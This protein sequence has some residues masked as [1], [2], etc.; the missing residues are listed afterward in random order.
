MQQR[1]KLSLRLGSE[2]ADAP[3][4][5]DLFELAGPEPATPPVDSRNDP[6]LVDDDNPVVKPEAGAAMAPICGEPWPG[7]SA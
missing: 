7:T 1:R 4:Q 2:R 5:A 6:A 3:E